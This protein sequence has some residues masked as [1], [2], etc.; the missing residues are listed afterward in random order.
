[1]LNRALRASL[2]GVAAA[3]VFFPP[4]A[5]AADTA[6]PYGARVILKPGN[7]FRIPAD[8]SAVVGARLNSCYLNVTGGSE[9][10]DFVIE[11]KDNVEGLVL[12][13]GETVTNLG[14]TTVRG[15]SFPKV[16]CLLS[17]LLYP[18]GA[19]LTASAAK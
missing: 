10:A 3:A 2:A 6:F 11:G 15:G 8:R 14:G 19:S 4:L 13:P 7:S 16:T 18:A 1:M 12:L 17:L 9:K 5:G